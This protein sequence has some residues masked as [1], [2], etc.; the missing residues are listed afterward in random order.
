M[1]RDIAAAG[2][3]GLA[4][5]ALVFIAACWTID[6]IPLLIQGSL[7]V[8]VAFLVVLALAL[9]EM[10][11]MVWALRKMARDAST[12]RLAVLGIHVAY[13]SFAAV[14]AAAF[15]LLTKQLPLAL[16]L[17]AVA[18]LRFVSGVWVR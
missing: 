14:Y 10:P 5:G 13:C 2:L 4:G 1:K 11:L 6:S 7:G 9:V 8:G 12:P 16:L 17:A 3:F 18:L 15:V